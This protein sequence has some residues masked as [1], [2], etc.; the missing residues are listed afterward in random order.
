MNQAPEPGCGSRIQIPIFIECKSLGHP[1]TGGEVI[2]K[3]VIAGDPV[4]IEEWLGSDLVVAHG[5]D[6]QVVWLT[7][8]DTG[9]ESAI[10]AEHLMTPS[11]VVWL[12]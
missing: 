10:V 2:V 9:G 12:D 1:S 4:R 6:V 5:T 8:A 7:A 3:I 11:G